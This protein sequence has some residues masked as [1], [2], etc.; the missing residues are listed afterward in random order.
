[1]QLSELDLFKKAS[2]NPFYVKNLEQISKVMYKVWSGMTKFIRSAIQQQKAPI[3]SEFGKFIPTN[4][5]KFIPA[6]SFLANAK[7]LFRNSSETQNS[8]SYKEQQISYSAIAEVCQI[9]RDMVMLCLKETLQQ[10]SV[11][12]SS[13]S[14]VVL[15]FRVGDLTVSKGWAEF[16]ALTSYDKPEGSTFISVSTPRNSCYTTFSE[17]SSIHPSNPN[18]IHQGASINLNNYY[19]G[20][21]YKTN[22][23]LLAPVGFYTGQIH[24]IFNFRTKFTRKQAFEQPL[25]PEE[26]LRFHQEQIRMKKAEKEL[27]K[28][29]EAGENSKTLKGFREIIESEKID[30][31]ATVTDKRKAYAIANLEQVQEKILKDQKAIDIKKKE[32][33][34]Y[35]PFTHG[36]IAEAKTQSLNVSMR[37]DM[38]NH[39]KSIEGSPVYNKEVTVGVP[40]FLQAS[41]YQAIRRTQN[42]HVEKTMNGTL[43]NY[44]EELKNKEKEKIRLRREKEEQEMN[45]AI[46]YKQ[47]EMYR[48]K[49]LENNL[50]AL[51]EQI[52]EKNRKRKE[53]LENKKNIYATSLDFIPESEESK[54]EKKELY[55]KNANLL[56]SQMETNERNTKDRFIKERDTDCKIL[57]STDLAITNEDNEAKIREIYTKS[58]NKDIWMKQMEIKALEKDVGKVL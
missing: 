45:D 29:K 15:H 4:P 46:Y 58:L 12:I 33:Y 13:G 35:F 55:I 20:L 7:V 28:E 40:K 48:K 53:E 30:K 52:E 51:N 50:N 36:D 49:E 11:S 43:K 37:E 32:V 5:V 18:P 27:E 56:I 39:L 14:T 57:Q 23:T 9:E 26:L 31:V 24:P 21:K 8:N 41:D 42:E 3:C 16:G 25:S 47:L 54:R 38:K 1:M 22:N 34:D 6:V 10:L 2:T 17:S 44:H 19:R